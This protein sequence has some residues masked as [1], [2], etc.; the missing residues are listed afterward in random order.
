MPKGTP[1]C[2]G[3]LFRFGLLCTNTNSQTVEAGAYEDSQ[4]TPVTPPPPKRKKEKSSLYSA[5]KHFIFFP[6]W[7]W[8]L[9]PQW[10]GCHLVAIGECGRVQVTAEE[11]MTLGQSQFSSHLLPG[12]KLSAVMRL[13]WVELAVHA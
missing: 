12:S 8:K 13:T 9:P 6:F 4:F 7:V 10:I 11:E 1:S 3:N 5:R 2:T